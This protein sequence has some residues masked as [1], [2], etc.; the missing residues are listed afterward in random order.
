MSFFEVV[1]PTVDVYSDASLV[2]PWY[3]AGHYKYAIAMSVPAVLNYAFSAYKWWSM[4]KKPEKKWTWAL[5]L[6]QF[7]QQFRALKVIRL[8]YKQDP[9]ASK[10]R[11]ELMKE[12]SSIEPFFESIPSIMIMTTIWL[13]AIVGY[14][15]YEDTFGSNS[16]IS[17]YS[18]GR[19]NCSN[20]YFS[21]PGVSNFC[22][23]FDGFGGP[24]WFFT[25]YAISFLAGSLGVT[26]FLQNGPC[27]ILSI[28]GTLGGLLR[29]RFLIA[30]LS[31]FLSIL[32]KAYMGG[33]SIVLVKT[34]GNHEYD[35]WLN[36]LIFSILS[37]LIPLLL[38]AMSILTVTG[39]SKSFT[40]VIFGYP[41]LLVLP[42]FTNFAVGPRQLP[43]CEKK[44]D[45]SEREQLIISRKLTLCNTLSTVVLY[46][47]N[48]SILWT[49]NTDPDAKQK[50][51]PV[52]FGVML[53]PGIVCSVLSTLIFVSLEAQCCCASSQ[54]CYI[55]CCCG[56]SCYEPRSECI[57]VSLLKQE[58][59]AAP[60]GLH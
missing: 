17:H 54:K 50:F 20:Q 31:I 21:Q 49:K 45:L 24:S 33:I 3:Y 46:A 57:K 29:W 10:K 19:F 26:K 38:S 18:K 37:F 1:L 22:A 40:K 43:C 55:P 12:I 59:E 47:I 34:P 15:S 60:E 7:W 8:I 6:I 30:Y 11:Q 35:I 41:A 23:V 56:P 44:S 42:A 13:N 36:P 27:S 25:T 28:N 51:L 2:I 32:A 14:G 53:G 58:I 4:E 5:L 48:V 16:A 52:Y 9:Q 39:F